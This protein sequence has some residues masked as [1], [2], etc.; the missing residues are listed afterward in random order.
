MDFC[1]LPSIR[2]YI[3][4]LLFGVCV[5]LKYF[6]VFKSTPILY[7]GS[8]TYPKWLV[9]AKLYHCMVT[10]PLWFLLSDTGFIYSFAFHSC[11][12]NLTCISLWCLVPLDLPPGSSVQMWLD[13]D[14]FV[15]AVASV[16]F[17][18]IWIYLFSCSYG[19]G[20]RTIQLSS[21][22]WFPDCALREPLVISL[23]VWPHH[24]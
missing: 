18:K 22:F 8:L 3:C 7:N 21:L 4:S 17:P 16:W 20:Q 13:L 19:A 6:C 10:L 12:E 15:T 14:F 9:L 11:I 24:C 1:V 5:L 23:T 2:M